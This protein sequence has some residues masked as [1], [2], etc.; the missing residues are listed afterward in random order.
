MKPMAWIPIVFAAVTA[1]ANWDLAGTTTAESQHRAGVPIE[2]NKSA[3]DPAAV[4]F[5]H[6]P[7]SRFFKSRCSISCTRFRPCCCFFFTFYSI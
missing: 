4:S 1:N 2:E 3:A 7:H 5:G 6:F